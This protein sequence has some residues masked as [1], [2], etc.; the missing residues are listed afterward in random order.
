MVRTSGLIVRCGFTLI[1]LLVVISIMALLISLL[2]P[3]LKHAKELGRRAS[4]MSNTK[5]IALGMLTYANDF[6]SFFPRHSTPGRAYPFIKYQPNDPFNPDHV[7]E[8]FELAALYMHDYVPYNPND[9]INVPY[10]PKLFYC[11]TGR[12]NVPAVRAHQQTS[13]VYYGNLEPI[14]WFPN[15]PENNDQY[16]D[17]LLMG[18]VVGGPDFDYDH[19][20]NHEVGDYFGANWAY[21]GGHVKWHGPSEITIQIDTIP[22]QPWTWDV[23]ETPVH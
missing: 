23:P 5:Q 7:Q 9:G 21:V 10:E 11:P 13:Y 17:W 1:E 18:D 4:C 6:S 14:G 15:S 2:L 20:G 3:A 19:Y 16:P 12:D 22:S 8:N